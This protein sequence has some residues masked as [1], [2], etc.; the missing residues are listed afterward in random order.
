MGFEYLP[1]IVGDEEV[2]T[3]YFSGEGE[4]GDTEV[5]ISVPEV[6]V[7]FGVFV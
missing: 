2:V 7:I 6:V 4:F 3:F 1:Y 5:S